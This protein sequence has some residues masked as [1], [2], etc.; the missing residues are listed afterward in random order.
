MITNEQLTFDDLVTSQRIGVEKIQRFLESE[1]RVF[2]LLGGAGFGKTTMIRFA[3][4][5]FLDEDWNNRGQNKRPNVA[6]ITLSHTAKG[7]LRGSV[8]DTHTFASAFGY[9]E[10]INEE[11]GER[12]FK[13]SD[14]FLEPPIGHE[15]IPIF[16][17]D[18]ISMYS[19]QMLDILLKEHPKGSKIILM[20]DQAQLPPPG[21][22][23]PNDPDADSPTFY[24]P[25]PEECQHELIEPVRQKIGNPILELSFLVR[26]QIFNEQN[27][28]TVISEILKPRIIEGI[29][30]DVQS[31]Q[32]CTD[33]FLAKAD[34]LNNKFIAFRIKE[35]AKLNKELRD[36]V[37]NHPEEPMMNNDIIFLTNN[38]SV[39]KP[40]FRLFNGDEYIVERVQKNDFR[41]M[42]RDIECHF[43]FIPNSR[44]NFPVYVITP[45][46]KGRH[47]YEDTLSELKEAALENGKLWHKYYRF[48]ESFTEFT[49][50][51]AIN[52][53]RAQG[54]TYQNVYFSLMDLLTI[55]IKRGDR[56]VSMSN[57]R[58]LQTIY[59]VITRA[60]QK[61]VFIKPD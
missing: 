22:E 48:K 13:P 34:Y 52:A 5:Q 37:F 11:T 36:L 32:Y 19:Q 12:T 40:E 60:S 18:E 23:D 45:T 56:W 50:G 1:H 27:L 49:M 29:G 51:F 55:K 28:N 4:K 24:L 30:Y 61:V 39:D 59:T 46:N 17:H 43:A 14:K 20:G 33:E 2:R 26:R 6:G 35:V 21:E 9:K 15:K 57:K 10:N 41:V 7:V 44:F 58:M 42:G 47:L 31:K 3:L 53:Y 38:F 16:V 25:L 8:H 54:K